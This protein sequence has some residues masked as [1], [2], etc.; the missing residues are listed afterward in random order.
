MVDEGELILK[1]ILNL[2]VISGDWEKM[3]VLLKQI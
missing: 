2:I 3:R 1:Y